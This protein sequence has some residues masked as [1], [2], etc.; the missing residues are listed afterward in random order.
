MSKSRDF[1]FHPKCSNLGITHLAYADDLLL[2]SRGDVR[3]VSMVMNCLNNFG[4]M[5]GLRVNLLKSNIY[6]AFI[7]EV[8]QEILNITGFSTGVLPFRYLGIPIASRRLRTSDYS[9]LIVSSASKIN[10]WQRHSLSYAGK[11]EL[12]RSVLQRV[13]CF[14]LSILPFPK[15]LFV[16]YTHYAES[17]CGQLNILRLHGNSLFEQKRM[18]EWG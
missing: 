8:R 13:E 5:A 16:T 11:V 10:A 12:I 4:D 6:M 3:S 2:L 9:L 14:W 18:M 15:I 1:G 7:G 17:L